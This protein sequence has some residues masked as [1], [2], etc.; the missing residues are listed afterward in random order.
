[1]K[2]NVWTGVE[3]EETTKPSVWTGAGWQAIQR[4]FV[5]TGTEWKQFFSDN[6]EPN[7]WQSVLDTGWSWNGIKVTWGYWYW[8]REDIKVEDV[9]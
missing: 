7:T 1:M 3:W 5:W 4:A 8:L 6:R 2:W 9:T